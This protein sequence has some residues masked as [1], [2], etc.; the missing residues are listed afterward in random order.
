MPSYGVVDAQEGEGLLPWSWAV[1][2]LTRSRIYLVATTQPDGAPH[3]MPVWGVWLNEGFSFSTGGQSRK[4]RNLAGD[5]RCV[6]TPDDGREAVVV[7]GLAQRVTDPARVASISTAYEQKYGIALPDAGG[8][9][10]FVVR[11]RVVFGLIDD[12]TRFAATATRWTF[13]TA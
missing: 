8:N 12:E 13:G 6:V 4:A 2:R 9:P 1:E 11:P 5:Q 10:V 3:L 7:E